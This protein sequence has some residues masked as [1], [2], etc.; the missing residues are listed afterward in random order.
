[1]AIKEDYETDT[2]DDEAINM[3]EYIGTKP[4]ECHA[5]KRPTVVKEKKK[6]S[7]AN[8]IAKEYS[9]DLTKVDEIFDALINDG[10]IKL[11]DGHVIPPPEDRAG[12]EYCK[13]HNLWRHTTNNCVIFRNV[14]QKA[15]DDGKL[16]FPGKGKVMTIGMM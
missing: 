14:I 15:I 5:L 9:F 12:K 6:V 10:K 16:L 8:Q 4:N 2:D 7:K 11:F 1:M 3:A 13:W